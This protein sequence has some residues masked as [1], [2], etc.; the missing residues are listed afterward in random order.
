MLNNA[1]LLQNDTAF[2]FKLQKAGADL[3]CTTPCCHFHP[4]I[5]VHCFCCWCAQFAYPETC[6]ICGLLKYATSTC[7][8]ANHGTT[9]FCIMAVTNTIVFSARGT[10]LVWSSFSFFV[11]SSNN[12]CWQE[13]WQKWA[14]QFEM[15]A[16]HFKHV[17]FKSPSFVIVCLANALL[18]SSPI[19]SSK[20]AWSSADATAS[21]LLAAI[22]RIPSA[23]VVF[24]QIF[25]SSFPFST[26]LIRSPLPADKHRVRVSH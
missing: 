17:S 2:T 14:W 16:L 26:R 7:S 13:Y 8:Y 5:D 22:K 12:A 20:S 1:P 25:C 15:Q 3:V 21:C 11:Y 6:C 10:F 24:L 9:S 19:S 18:L 4:N 23:Q